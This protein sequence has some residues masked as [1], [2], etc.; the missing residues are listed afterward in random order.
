M[1]IRRKSSIDKQY[2]EKIAQIAASGKIPSAKDIDT[3][4]EPRDVVLGMM[5]KSFPSG[6]M[7]SFKGVSPA[8]DRSLSKSGGLYSPMCD[9]DV[10]V[11]INV[12]P[13]GN[14]SD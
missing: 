7:K 8:L 11:R 1:P 9:Q 6:V 14:L 5:A 12:D 13:I 4:T 2:Y 10:V 3:D